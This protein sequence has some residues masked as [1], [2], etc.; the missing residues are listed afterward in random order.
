MEK[1][2]SRLFSGFFSYTLS[3][4][5]ESVMMSFGGSLHWDRASSSSSVVQQVTTHF[6][7]SSSRMVCTWGS[8]RRPSGAWISWGMTN[9]TASPRSTRSPVMYLFFS[10]CL[11]D[12]MNSSFRA[13]IPSLVT[14]LTG[15]TGM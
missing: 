13:T 9:R 4:T 10:V 11:K 6:R 14:A 3:N 8:I 2:V 5:W 1:E 7:S 15:R 12:R